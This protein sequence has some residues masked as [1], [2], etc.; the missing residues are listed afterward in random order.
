MRRASDRKRDCAAARR[1]D[2]VSK[3]P[4][5]RRRPPSP[6]PSPRRAADQRD[7][8]FKILDRE[9]QEPTTPFDIHGIIDRR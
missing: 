3:F 7:A 4:P 2:R 8:L 6:S 1:G 5:D 9:A